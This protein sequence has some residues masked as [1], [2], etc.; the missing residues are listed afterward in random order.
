MNLN[1]KTKKQNEWFQ[2][3]QQLATENL[4]YIGCLQNMDNNAT[5][6]VISKFETFVTALFC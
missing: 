3:N 5:T 2:P 4:V 1:L 6:Y